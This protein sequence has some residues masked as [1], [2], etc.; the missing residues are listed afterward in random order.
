M[1]R[2][3]FGNTWWGKKWLDAL[4][5]T[6]YSNRLP[7]G[8]S[9]A[10]KGSVKQLSILGNRVEASVQG[11]RR[12]PYKVEISLTA[13]NATQQKAVVESIA[14][15]PLLLSHLLIRKLPPALLD[16][17]EARKVPLF[18]KSWGDI[19]AQ[20]SCPDWAACCKH[21][22]AVIYMIA[23]EIDKNPF[24]LFDLHEF[25]LFKALEKK[26][27]KTEKQAALIPDVK[28]FLLKTHPEKHAGA[29]DIDLASLD[30]TTLEKTP[31][32]LA[33]LLPESPLFYPEKDFP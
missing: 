15:N 17:F 23:N 13:F 22:A 8:M 33:G 16:E 1:A 27:F 19:G 26:G 29:I 32:A 25:D 9:Y 7:R 31:G 18:P 11:S 28:D 10:R 3:S 30:F 5:R 20:C 21:I 2:I 14:G 12:T 6:D 4:A 24:I